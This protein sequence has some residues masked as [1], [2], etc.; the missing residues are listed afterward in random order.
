LSRILQFASAVLLGGL[1]L[2]DPDS[3]R[4]FV[5]CGFQW[6]SG[7][8]CP[9]CGMTRALSL[10]ERGEWQRAVAMHPLSP[11]VF[12]LVLY[13]VAAVRPLPG[14]V[15]TTFAALLLAFGA[16]RILLILT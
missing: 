8:P 15:W 10:L 4:H 12:L 3:P 9:L 11:L 7:L 6:L 14:W 5:L 1:R 2:Y 16:A 13:S